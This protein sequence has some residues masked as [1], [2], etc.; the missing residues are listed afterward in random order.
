[1]TILQAYE[2]ANTT[3]STKCS[4][5]MVSIFSKCPHIYEL[6]DMDDLWK[7]SAIADNI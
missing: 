7:I 1:M 5:E 2:K 4:H 3:N 6:V